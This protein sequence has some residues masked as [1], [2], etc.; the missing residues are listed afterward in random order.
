MIADPQI[1]QQAETAALNCRKWPI[2]SLMVNTV[3]L[4]F[5]VPDRTVAEWFLLEL[6][7]LHWQPARRPVEV[8]NMLLIL[9]MSIEIPQP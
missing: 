1:P 5:Y 2:D 8:Q 6:N 4:S 7:G 3:L 9:S